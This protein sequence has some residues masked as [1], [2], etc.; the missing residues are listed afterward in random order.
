MVVKLRHL[1]TT[2]V[3]TAVKLNFFWKLIEL[4]KLYELLVSGRWTLVVRQGLIQRICESLT[5]RACECVEKVLGSVEMLT[6]DNN[7]T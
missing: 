1:V 2:G 6:K 4:R 5:R 3:S 7:S